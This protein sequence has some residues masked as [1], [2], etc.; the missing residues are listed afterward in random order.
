MPSAKP[1]AVKPRAAARKRSVADA[2][3]AMDTGT[4]ANAAL[5]DPDKPLTDKQRAFVK[6]WAGGESIPNAAARAGYTDGGSFAYRMAHMP[7]VLKLYHEEKQAFERDNSMNRKR[8]LDGL[9]EGIE[10][11]K[12]VSEPA[13]VINGWKTIGQMCGYFEPVKV[14]HEH[15][16]EGKIIVD[17]MNRMSDEELFKLIEERTAQMQQLQQPVLAGDDDDEP[18]GGA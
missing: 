12:M 9:I 5:V 17:R 4:I 3:K 6:L 8:V 11:A 1:T 18:G 14:K 13:S 7:N 2:R 15:T 16:I 10:L